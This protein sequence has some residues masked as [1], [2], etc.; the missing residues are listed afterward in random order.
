MG[1]VVFIA[2]IRYGI[3]SMGIEL[4]ENRHDIA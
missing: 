1:H 4:V 2:A 3:K